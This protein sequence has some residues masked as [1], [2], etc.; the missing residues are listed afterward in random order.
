MAHVRQSRPYYRASFQ[1]EV[2]K[3]FDLVQS[4]I[5]DHLFDVTKTE[6]ELQ[7]SEDVPS[8]LGS[9]PTPPINRSVDG[10]RQIERE[11]ERA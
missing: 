1:V 11:R 8:W 4:K 3:V 2:V 7:I 10:E 9:G 5:S 6:R